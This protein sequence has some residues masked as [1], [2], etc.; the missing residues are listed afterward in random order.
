MLNIRAHIFVSGLVQ[1]VFF[2]DFTQRSAEILNLKGWVRNTQDGRVEV[3]C[4]GEKEDILEL[5]E[6]LKQGPPHARV[7]DVK[8]IWEEFRKEFTNFEIR[9]Y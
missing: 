1:G 9:W 2:R 5:I 6:N 3:V 4:E 8:V 7:K